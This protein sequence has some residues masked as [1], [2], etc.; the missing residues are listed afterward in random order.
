MVFA[1]QY[2]RQIIYG[3]IKANIGKVLRQMVSI[4]KLLL[5]EAV[6]LKAYTFHYLFLCCFKHI[7]AIRFVDNHHNTH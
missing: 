5:L 2:R 7:A 6:I 3:Q 4:R 1:P